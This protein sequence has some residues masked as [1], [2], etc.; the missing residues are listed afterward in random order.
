MKR[1]IKK[2]LKVLASYIHRMDRAIVLKNRIAYLSICGSL[3]S[4]DKEFQETWESDCFVLRHNPPA[5]PYI[6][7]N[8]QII[9][10]ERKFDHERIH[11][12]S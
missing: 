10:I 6:K 3:S 9:E 7:L 12:S 5:T 4:F 1:F 11:Q 8:I 2:F